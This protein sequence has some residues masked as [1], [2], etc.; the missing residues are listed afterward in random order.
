MAASQLPPEPPALPARLERAVAAFKGL[1]LLA[2]ITLLAAGASRAAPGLRLT[3]PARCMGLLGRPLCLPSRK[4]EK[5]EDDWPAD[6]FPD[7]ATL[8]LKSPAAPHPLAIK[9]V[10]HAAAPDGDAR[11]VSSSVS[12]GPC[13]AASSGSSSPSKLRSGAARPRSAGGYRKALMDGLRAGWAGSR[14]SSGGSSRSS[15]PPRRLTRARWPAALAAAALALALAGVWGA[16]WAEHVA[17][18]FLEQAKA[19]PVDGQYSRF[20]LMVRRGDVPARRSCETRT[21]TKQSATAAECQPGGCRSL[22]ARFLCIPP[23]RPS[24]L[25]VCPT[26]QPR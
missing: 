7:G 6:G 8:S 10:V 17:E 25:M 23:H 18:P 24:N 22:L 1:A 15:S 21:A 2:I 20:T 9:L 4:H 11:S 13:S 12:S 26:N 5:V 3:T 19:V 16:R 14:P